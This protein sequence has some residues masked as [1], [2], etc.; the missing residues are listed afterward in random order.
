MVDL[1]EKRKIASIMEHRDYPDY[2]NKQRLGRLIL[3]NMVNRQI[4]EEIE[5]TYQDVCGLIASKP[6]SEDYDLG[7]W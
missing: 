3:D 4:E 5:F 2:V 6:I 1:E 7:S